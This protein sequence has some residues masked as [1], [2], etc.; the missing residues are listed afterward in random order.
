MT[1]AE[2]AT[3]A[4]AIVASMLLGVWFLYELGRPWRAPVELRVQAWLQAALVA[5][6]VALDVLLLLV[7]LRIAPPLWL[8]LA[9]LLGQDAVYGWRLLV[10]VR[11]HRERTRS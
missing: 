2:R 5:T 9:V 1:G 8:I 10:L 4:A 3:V 11:A 7:V 6:P